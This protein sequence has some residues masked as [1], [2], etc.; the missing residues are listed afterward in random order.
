MSYALR[1]VSLRTDNSEAGMARIEEVWRDVLSGKLPLLFDNEGNPL[2]G[3]SPISRYSGYESDEAGTYDLTILVVKA[4]FFAQMEQKVA[5][6]AYKKYDCA[7]AD[8]FEAVRKAWSQV[9]DDAAAGTIERAFTE[10]YESTVPAQ[11][12]KDSCD[13]CYLYISTR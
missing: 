11:Y 4:D 10:D 12:T 3:L 5:A 8:S 6:G 1:S 9:W 2:Q 13:H 7:G